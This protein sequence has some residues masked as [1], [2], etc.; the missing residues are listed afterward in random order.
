MNEKHSH[1]Q[2]WIFVAITHITVCS[3]LS[4]FAFWTWFGIDIFKI[5]DISSL[6]VS[7]AKPIILSVAVL[8]FGWLGQYLM[9]SGPE[10]TEGDFI[11]S[12]EKFI[13][14][15]SVIIS[16]VFLGVTIYL[17]VVRQ[18]CWLPFSIVII[19]VSCVWYMAVNMKTL[20]RT[21]TNE[22]ARRIILLWL[23]SVPSFSV[24]YS[25]FRAINLTNYK[26]NSVLITL[27]QNNTISTPSN[28]STLSNV[29]PTDTLN[30]IGQTSSYC[31][32]MRPLSG[33]VLQVPVSEIGS[34]EHLDSVFDFWE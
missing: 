2:F 11:N 25:V 6:T 14:V 8:F 30:F 7:A 31:F 3:I 24:A 18:V 12:D 32:F 15:L 17:A 26:Y 28:E 20:H 19:L 16:I 34:M 13:G 1:Y 10:N 27:K 33:D 29:L 5:L 22:Y 23:I 9:S 4:H 21:V